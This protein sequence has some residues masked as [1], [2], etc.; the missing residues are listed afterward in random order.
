MDPL[1]ITLTLV[2][3]IILLVGIVVSFNIA[4]KQNRHL[5]SKGKNKEAIKHP[6]ILNPVILSYILTVIAVA[7]GS[8]LFYWLFFSE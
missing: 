4:K 5:L 7:V 3:L 1:H 6:V 8:A 2:V